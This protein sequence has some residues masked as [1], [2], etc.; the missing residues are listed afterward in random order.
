MPG[1]QGMYVG[2][3]SMLAG[4]L[5]LGTWGR[6][7]PRAAKVALVALG[8]LMAVTTLPHRPPDPAPGPTR[9]ASPSP[10][11]PFITPIPSPGSMHQPA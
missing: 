1:V 6:V 5:G 9:P 8:M 3:F 7:T 4:S 10:V 2:M 11:H